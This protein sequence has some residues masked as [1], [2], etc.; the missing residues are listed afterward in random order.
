MSIVVQY[1]VDCHIYRECCNFFVKNNQPSL[2]F[3]A[4]YYLCKTMLK[5]MLNRDCVRMIDDYAFKFCFVFRR[6]TYQK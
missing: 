3:E 6:I 1:D 5:S 2:L 4:I